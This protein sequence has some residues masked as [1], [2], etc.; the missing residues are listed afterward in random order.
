M[1][2]DRLIDILGNDLVSV[3]EASHLTR[4]K[5]RVRA[6]YKLNIIDL[7]KLIRR[8]EADELSEEEID[9][10]EELVGGIQKLAELEILSHTTDDWDRRDE[11]YCLHGCCEDT[12]LPE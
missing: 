2:V 6:R 5:R 7:M 8:V 12:L 1:K 10:L 9:D 3:E 11:W 4:N